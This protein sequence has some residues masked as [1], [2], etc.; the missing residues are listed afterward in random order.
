M[1]VC[2]T[3]V[4]TIACSLMSGCGHKSAESSLGF[5]FRV[6][7]QTETKIWCVTGMCMLKVVSSETNLDVEGLI[8]EWGDRV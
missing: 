4:L 8:I 2:Q 6:R 1:G 3:R 5:V 7:A